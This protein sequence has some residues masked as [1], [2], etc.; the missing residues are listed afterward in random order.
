M[1]RYHFTVADDDLDMLVLIEKLLITSIP[2]CEVATFTDGTGALQHIEDNDVDLL[3]S[4]HNMVCMGGPEL[5]RKTRLQETS[6][7]IIMISSDPDEKWP[8]RDC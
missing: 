4:N 1:N 7:P 3:I 6:I 5:I 2:N 8:L